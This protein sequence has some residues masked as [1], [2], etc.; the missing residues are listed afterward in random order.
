MEQAFSDWR[1]QNF[2]GATLMAPHAGFLL[3]ARCLVPFAERAAWNQTLQGLVRQIAA[4]DSV[5]QSWQPGES[6]KFAKS[7][8][9]PFHNWLLG[10]FRMLNLPDYP[11]DATL[12]EAG[13]L[14]GFYAVPYLDLIKL[15]LPLVIQ[16]LD[17]GYTVLRQRRLELSFSEQVQP[18][19]QAVK[20][21]PGCLPASSLMEMHFDLWQQGINWYW[22]GGELTIVGQGKR[23]RRYQ[24]L[25]QL[26]SAT[27]AGSDSVTAE[28]LRIPIYTVTGS[29]GKTT[30]ARLLAQLLRHSG[31]CLA[32]TASDGAW[33]GDERVLEGD[34]IGGVS[35]RALLR[36]SRVEAAVFEQGRGGFL[37]QGVPY[38]CSDV[39]VLLNVQAVHLG[40]YG[41]ETLADMA[42]LKALGLQPAKL[43]VLNLDDF[44]VC[45]LGA[46][47]PAQNCVWFSLAAPA[48]KLQTLSLTAGG[49]LGVQRDSQGEPHALAIWQA[50]ELVKSL[51]LQGV[52][53][54]HGLLGDKTLEE[55]AAAVAAAWF[56]PLPLSG[57][58]HLLRELTLNNQNHLFRTSIHRRGEIF[59]VLDK[60]AE[61][62]S[63]EVLLEVIEDFCL[64]EKIARRI[65][66]LVRSAGE[67][68]ARHLESCIC[69]HRYMDEFACFDR[70]ETYTSKVALPIYT[71]GSIPKI[72]KDELLR[73]NRETGIDKP[74]H[75]FPDW[76]AAEQ[77]L[78]RRL[79]E[80][81]GRTL[82]L[83]N[84]P[85][86]S[87]P[88]LNK[89][90][91]DF[92]QNGSSGAGR[93][94]S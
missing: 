92:V 83:I 85:T 35:A 87:A 52:A 1:M 58:E 55:L 59:F 88:A 34:C 89:Q 57:W 77:W 60:A 44:E 63:L 65:A 37:R 72:L 62:A 8:H 45:R 66:L 53:P 30:T 73:L 51:S 74:V 81:T 21:L 68:L 43:A 70:I 40:L 2:C 11:I 32:L 31:L 24:G 94:Q 18:W 20:A 38:T 12:D 84:Q 15:A 6:A 48:A 9:D 41:I 17:W 25:R 14:R 46:Q 49:A 26:V 13:N 64:R 3:T 69:L 75:T 36:D 79:P 61:K 71:P 16:L 56:G 47:R 27:K 22:S 28:D 80:L 29:V 39:A 42:Q 50:G 4:K 86:T 54:Y 7:E 82:V 91:V 67:P 5:L 90:I 33:I 78:S 23:Q 10:L 19:L 76:S 93:S